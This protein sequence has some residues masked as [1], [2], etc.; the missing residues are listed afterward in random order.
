MSHPLWYTMHMITN[1]MK[2]YKATYTSKAPF[3]YPHG[4]V[5]LHRRSTDARVKH[6]T[7]SVPPTYH[8]IGWHTAGWPHLETV[9]V[10]NPITKRM[11]EI[12]SSDEGE[13][14]TFDM[15]EA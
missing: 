2:Q 11:F 9:Q 1:D 3:A 4:K 5:T 8:I 13:T 7:P 14:F 12:Y 6:P 15:V 10:W